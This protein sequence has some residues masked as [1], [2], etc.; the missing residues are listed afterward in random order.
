[1]Y[2][3]VRLTLV[4]EWNNSVGG[5]DFGSNNLDRPVCFN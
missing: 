4:N 2:F 3:N 5:A 1:M